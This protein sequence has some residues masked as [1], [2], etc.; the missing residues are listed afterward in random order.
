M[1]PGFLAK[2]NRPKTEVLLK[3][4]TPFGKP[5]SH[6]RKLDTLFGNPDMLFVKPGTPYGKPS[7]HFERPEMA[8]FFKIW[9]WQ[10]WAGI[11]KSKNM[12]FYNMS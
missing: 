9:L 8:D 3:Q 1:S 11:R 4:S 12:M 2:K 5:G 7:T 6:F 10:F